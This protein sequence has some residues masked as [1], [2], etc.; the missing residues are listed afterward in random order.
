MFI[1]LNLLHH[2]CPGD[3][4]VLSAAL[5]A[6]HET[7]PG[8]YETNVSSPHRALLLH[9]PHL[10]DYSG[11]KS[12]IDYRLNPAH[13]MADAYVADLSRIINRPLSLTSQPKLYLSNEEQEPLADLPK[14]YIV[15][16]AG[17]KPDMTVKGLP[18]ETAEEVTKN[19]PL[20]CIQLGLPQHNEPVKGAIDLRGKTSLRQVMRIAAHAR[21]GFGGDTFLFHC[22][23]ALGTPYVCIA[24]PRLHL[25]WL[26][27]YHNQTLLTAMGQ[28][29]C[30]KNPCGMRRVEKLGDG[31]CL[32]DL[33][34]LQPRHDYRLPVAEC[35]LH[36]KSQQI[37][38]AINKNLSAPA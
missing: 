14:D 28:L 16:N 15:F 25:K 17:R 19:A 18:L 3:L 37:I 8:E 6:L 7:Y 27:L 36:I 10:S 24:P 13:T 33:I 9:N 38:E 23:G 12:P 5:A 29:D 4:I 20:P 34:C 31:S 32:D 21:A 35:M 22:C 1:K 11:N 30:C 2:R 26:E